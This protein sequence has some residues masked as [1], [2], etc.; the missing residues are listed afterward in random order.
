MMFYVHRWNVDS[1]TFVG[2]AFANQFGIIIAK[3]FI[4]MYYVD[5]SEEYKRIE[6]GRSRRPR[7]D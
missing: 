5:P 7:F 2:F 1:A 3:Y 4:V 6:N